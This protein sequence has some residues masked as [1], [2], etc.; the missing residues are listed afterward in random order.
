M[1]SDR[2]SARLSA[3]ETPPLNYSRIRRKNR[4]GDGRSLAEVEGARVFHLAR[5]AREG[6]G[7][8]GASG[9]VESYRMCAVEMEISRTR[10]RR[11]RFEAG[12]L[13]GVGVV[14]TL[15]AAKRY[16]PIDLVLERTIASVMSS[17]ACM[18]TCVRG[19]ID[20]E[21]APTRVLSAGGRAE[22]GG[23]EGEEE[24]V[25]AKHVYRDPGNNYR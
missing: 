20:R 23:G 17:R 9:P 16:Q 8:P 11:K 3:P 15:L 25:S 7:G 6:G 24:E 10:P 18:C 14:R 5:G 12:R 4:I 21:R 22:G 1:S 2:E 13:S 19:A